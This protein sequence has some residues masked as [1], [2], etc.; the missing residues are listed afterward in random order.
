MERLNLLGI[1]TADLKEEPQN[2]IF[3]TLSQLSSVV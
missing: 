1:F 2:V 3:L